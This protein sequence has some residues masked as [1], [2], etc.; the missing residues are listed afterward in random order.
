MGS[1]GHYQDSVVG[2]V[3]RLSG[4]TPPK[5]SSPFLLLTGQEVAAAPGRRTGP[6]RAGVNSSTG[7]P[8]PDRCV[9]HQSH[10]P[11]QS[12]MCGCAESGWFRLARLWVACRSPRLRTYL[13]QEKMAKHGKPSP[14]RSS[15]ATKSNAGYCWRS[16]LFFLMASLLSCL[17]TCRGVRL[18]GR[19]FRIR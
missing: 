18:C 7:V 11:S 8:P 13:D 17:R 9:P 12:L 6:D 15:T 10:H 3:S 19:N 16:W 14:A 4:Q 5:I 1:T 2:R